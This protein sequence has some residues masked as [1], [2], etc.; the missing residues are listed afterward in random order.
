MSL[1]TRNHRSTALGACTD[2]ATDQHRD[3]HHW[4]PG[5]IAP[6]SAVSEHTTHRS[7]KW[8]IFERSL[9]PFSTML[10]AIKLLKLDICVREAARQFG[11][12]YN[13]VYRLHHLLRTATLC[14]AEN[15]A[16]LKGGIGL[17][18]SNCGGWRK[19]NRRSSAAGKIPVFGIP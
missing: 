2:P 4:S 14:P 10:L 15:A 5:R 16:S 13:P 6:V 1:K 11:L 8:S 19:G 17:N 9:V 12:A 7:V 3:R 18:E